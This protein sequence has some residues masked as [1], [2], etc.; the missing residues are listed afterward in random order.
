VVRRVQ[1]RKRSHRQHQITTCGEANEKTMSRITQN[2]TLG[3][4][5]NLLKYQDA[6][7]L[8]VLGPSAEQREREKA[9]GTGRELFPTMPF[10][11]T[12]KR[13]GETQFGAGKTLHE[14]L[15]ELFHQLERVQ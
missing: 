11:A 1:S 15:D 12:A 6:S 14:A 10:S 8:R 9:G 7:H 5:E 2:T 13:K 3:E 4:L